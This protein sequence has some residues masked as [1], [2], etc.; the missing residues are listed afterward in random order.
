MNIT[1]GSY[2]PWLHKKGQRYRF[3]F[4]LFVSRW[5]HQSELEQFWLDLHDRYIAHEVG[6]S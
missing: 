5:Y 6:Q 4:R 1:E 2:G 3:G